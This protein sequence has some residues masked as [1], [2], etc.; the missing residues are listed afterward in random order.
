V[1][2]ALFFAV[3]GARPW[4]L[5]LSALALHVGLT[6]FAYGILRARLSDRGAVLLLSCVLVFTTAAVHSYAVNPPREASLFLAMAAL[7]AA[8]RVAASP[9]PEVPMAASGLL[10]GFACYADPYA[11]LMY[12]AWVMFAV[13]AIF[14]RAAGRLQDRAHP[15]RWRLPAVGTAAAVLGLAP[16]WALRHAPGAANGPMGLEL[17]VVGHN[18]TLLTETCGP[19]AVGLRVHAA[20]AVMDYVPWEAPFAIRAIQLG[21]FLAYLALCVAGLVASLRRRT[22]WPL[23][24][25]GLLGSAMLVGTVA[26]FLTSVMV[27]DQFSMRYLATLTIMAPFAMAPAFFG[28]SP[29]PRKI[30]LSAL[31]LHLLATAIGGWVSFRPYVDGPLP[32]RSEA[33]IAAA[34]FAL[35]D[36][37]RARGVRYATAD[38]WASYRLTF[39][40]REDVIVVPKNPGEDRYRKYRDAFDRAPAIAYV[41]DRFRSRETLADAESAAALLGHIEA[42]VTLGPHTVYFVRR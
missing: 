29:L 32:V 13:F 40:F 18:W 22:P 39:L 6:L 2:A 15:N 28:L 21:G 25:L 41:H 12:P 5:I 11:K 7:Y 23:R 42:R 35:G 37:L 17:G 14:E 27:M 33:G 36:L 3:L 24:T 10:A 16:D 38:Y 19:W 20:N 1:V 31:G 8:S 34:D 9:R 4:V 30:A 26:S